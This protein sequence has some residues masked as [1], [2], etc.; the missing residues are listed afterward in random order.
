MADA[1]K[2]KGSSWQALFRMGKKG[3]EAIGVAFDAE[4]QPPPSVDPGLPDVA[5]LVVFLRTKGWV[6]E[7]LNQQG[8][9]AVNCPLDFW[10]S[11][12]IVVEESLGV[13]GPHAIAFS[14]A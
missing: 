12:C 7:N 4:I 14:I 2:E 6:A 10:E 3:E 9:S 5:S 13:K 1:E 11:A 8:D